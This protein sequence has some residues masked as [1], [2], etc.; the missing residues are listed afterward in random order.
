MEEEQPP[1]NQQPENQTPQTLESQQKNYFKT[2][3]KELENQQET[4]NP[5]MNIINFYKILFNEI[6]NIN[7]DMNDVLKSYKKDSKKI[8]PNPK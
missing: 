5:T 6:S 8:N 2:F 3:T 7:L 1:T 4:V